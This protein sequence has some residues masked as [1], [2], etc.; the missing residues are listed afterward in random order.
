MEYSKEIVEDILNLEVL[1][2]Q[3]KKD[4]A[5]EALNHPTATARMLILGGASCISKV[6]PKIE[7]NEKNGIKMSLYDIVVEVL[8]TYGITD[9]DAFLKEYDHIFGNKK[10]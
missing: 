6:L 3:T 2:H 9:V 4:Y 7:Q 5:K 10:R 8:A 1:I